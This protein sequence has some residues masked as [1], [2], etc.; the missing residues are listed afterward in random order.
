MRGARF[1]LQDIP[2]RLR[3]IP[4]DAGSTIHDW[5][6]LSFTRDHPRGCGEHDMNTS[7]SLSRRGSS[8]RMRG[9]PMRVRVCG[10]WAGIIPADAGSTQRAAPRRYLQRDH[11]RGCGEHAMLIRLGVLRSGSSPRMRGAL[12][13]NSVAVIGARI[14]PA[15]AGSTLCRRCL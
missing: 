7:I 9:A 6:Y 3:I 1:A 14:I 13:K 15:D 8:P 10:L 11:P 5:H 4:A 12:L 2:N